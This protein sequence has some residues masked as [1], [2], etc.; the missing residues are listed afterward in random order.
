M[1]SRVAVLGSNS[2]TGAHFVDY[3]L[4]QTSALVRGYSRSEEV[5]RLFSPYRSNQ[6]D[7]SRFRFERLDV[8]ADFDHLT[9]SLDDFEPEVVV[10]F[11]A[12]GE[13]RNSWRWPEHW[14]QTNTFAVVK[15]AEFL[16]ERPYL[17]RYLTP[18]TPEVYGATGPEPVAESHQYLPSTPYGVSKLAGDLHLLALH[19]RQEFPVLLTRAAN[20][21]GIHQQLYRIIPKTA[22]V[23]K[24]GQKLPL[25][26]GGRAQ[27]TFIHARD[28]ACATWTVLT[29]GQV[30][31]VYHIAPPPPAL[32]TIAEVVSLV[33]TRLGRRL[34]DVVEMQ[35]DNFGQDSV[36]CMDASRLMAL[37]W[38]PAVEFAAGVDETVDWIEANWESVRN[39]SCEYEHQR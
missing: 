12:Q 37:G 22:I 8:N 10:N 25:H 23:I 1:F 20:L 5:S 9:R 7:L 28:V 36:F 30:G 16:K 6:R 17:K 2:F 3:L 35:E 33:C 39:L 24:K 11:A 26:G 31:Q 19:R 15:L 29:R 32:Q 34:Q 21:Y 4:E 38:K 27:R 14:Y 18:S 13:V